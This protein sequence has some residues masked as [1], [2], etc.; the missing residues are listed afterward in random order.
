MGFVSWIRDVKEVAQME[1]A[2]QQA[3]SFQPP[4]LSFIS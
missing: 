3:L 1:R 4:F 2:V